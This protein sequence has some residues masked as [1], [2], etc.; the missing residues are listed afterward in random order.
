VATLGLAEP[1]VATLL[2]VLVLAGWA[3]AALVAAG[4]GLQGVS[5]VRPR[6]DEETPIVEAA[7][8]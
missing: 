2:G 8:V 7:P 5:S 3:G 1:Q 4:L 6:E